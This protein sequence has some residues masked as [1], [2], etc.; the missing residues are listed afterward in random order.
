MKIRN[1]YYD[2][3]DYDYYDYDYDYYVGV[4]ILII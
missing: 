3:Y 2:Y 1:H 4:F